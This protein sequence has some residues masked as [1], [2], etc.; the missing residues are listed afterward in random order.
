MLEIKG[1]QVRLAEG[2]KEILKGVDLKIGRAR[3]TRSWAERV[4]QVDHVL[5]PVRA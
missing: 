1:L 2:G 4:G 3:C 5:C